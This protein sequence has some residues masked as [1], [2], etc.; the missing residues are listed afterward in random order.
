[1]TWALFRKTF[2]D[3]RWLLLAC[4]GLLFAFSWIRVVIV[5]SMELYQ[6]ERL[7]RNLP[8]I[9]K[10]LSPVPLETLVSYAGLIG[11]TYEEPVTYLIMA[12]WCISRGSDCISGEIAAGTM[13]MLL[14]QP[15][16]RLRYLMTH[17]VVTLLGI[18]VLS[19]A[20]QFGTHAGLLKTGIRRPAPP[21]PWSIPFLENP[22]QTPPTETKWVS[23][24][25]THFV[26]PQVFWTATINYA[27]LGAFLAGITYL[28]SSWDRY[29]WRTIGIVVG[30]YVVETILELTGMAVDGWHW[31]LHLTFFSAYEP[32]AF[33]TAVNDQPATAWQFWASRST[34]YLPDLGPLGCDLL[35]LAMGVASLIAAAIVFCRR[36]LP[37]PL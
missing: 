12:V 19:L 7:A 36:D 31:L 2:H 11:F 28:T 30:F 4:A 23:I 1:V 22:T 33:V 26:K 16:S 32:V 21:F 37:A 18:A 6:F 20:T 27:C 15:V 3:A 10:R 29:R 34:G 14:A 13:E 5:S 35:L 8:E 9:V 17:V 24:P 25:M